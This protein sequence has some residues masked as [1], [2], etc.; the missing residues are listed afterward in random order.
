MGDP[1]AIP[2]PM[3]DDPLHHD[4]S[5]FCCDPSC[6]CHEDPTLIEPVAQAVSEGL[7]TAEEASAFVAGKTL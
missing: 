6:P 3:E 4:L 2:I 1:T 5:P 7:L